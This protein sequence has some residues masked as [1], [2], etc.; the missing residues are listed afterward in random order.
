MQ[1]LAPYLHQNELEILLF[2]IKLHL[3]CFYVSFGKKWKE[4]PLEEKKIESCKCVQSM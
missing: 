4:L 2:F 1:F 3:I